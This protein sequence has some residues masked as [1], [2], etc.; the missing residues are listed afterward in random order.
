MVH[1]NGVYDREK[2]QD[3]ILE[4]GV[5]FIYFTVSDFYVIATSR[6]AGIEKSV[7]AEKYGMILS[8]IY[9]YN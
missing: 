9:I 3:I 5:N 4:E 2:K 8:N 7:Y 1:G 6:V